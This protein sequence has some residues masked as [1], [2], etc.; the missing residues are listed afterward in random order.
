MKSLAVAE[1]FSSLQGEGYWAG[2]PM[3]FV[4]LAGCSVGQSQGPCH[5]YDGRQFICDT[6][7]TKK[8]SAEPEK[9]IENAGNLKHLCITGGEP[10]IHHLDELIFLARLKDIYV[11]IETSGTIVT[12]RFFF[13]GVRYVPWICVSPK[14]NYLEGVIE[15]ADEL[16]LLIDSHFDEALLPPCILNHP[17]VYIQPVNYEKTLNME[18]MKLCL[19]LLDK[20]PEWH[21]SVQLHKILGLR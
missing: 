1:E 21:L 17:D 15:D 2:T 9:L 5:T 12:P 3:Y 18:N 6:N 4:R 13:K 14:I 7:F 11:H 19:A 16:K 8:Y 10:L 20:H